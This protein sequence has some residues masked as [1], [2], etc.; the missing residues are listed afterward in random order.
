MVVLAAYTG[1]RWSETA[2]LT[3]SKAG[4]RTLPLP[5]LAIA[6]LRLHLSLYLL[7]PAGLVFTNPAVAVLNQNNWRHRE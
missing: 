4:I 5:A 3:K 1:M 7:G 2:G 6:E